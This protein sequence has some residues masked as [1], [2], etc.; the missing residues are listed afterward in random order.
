MHTQGGEVYDRDLT[1]RSFFGRIK[2]IDDHLDERNELVFWP[3]SKDPCIGKAAEGGFLYGELQ[4][5]DP[6][7][8][9]TFDFVAVDEAAHVTHGESVHSALTMAA[10]EGRLYLS[11]PWGDDNFHARLCDDR[12]KGWSYLRL[13]WSTHPVYSAG[14][15]VAGESLECELCEGNRQGLKWSAADPRAHRYPGKLTS[16]WYDQAVLDKT[17]EQVASELDIDRAGAL[18]ARVYGEFE[19]GVHEVPAGVPY[20]DDV[21][22]E[23]GWDFGLDC[24][25]VPVIQ[26]TPMCVNVI[27]LFEAGDKFKWGGMP[28][29]VALGLRE[30]LVSIGVPPEAVGTGTRCVG[31]PSGA[32]RD[33]TSA[34]LFAAYR[35]QGFFIQPPPKA[36][37]GRVD[38]S[39]TSV[40]NLLLGRPKPVRVCGVNGREFSRHMLNNVWPT[41][42]EGNRKIGVG[43]TQPLDNSH[44]HACRAFAYW[45]VSTFPPAGRRGA[46]GRSAADRRLPETAGIPGRG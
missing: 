42:R 8:G 3:F 33:Q 10:P 6:G 15:H 23:L 28:E 27:G 12:P 46:R 26:N 37:R 5:D 11:T 32:Y 40:K 36:W 39:V 35:E 7:R 1:P 9:G 25:A 41:D 22:V 34:G 14:L 13:H 44:N 2:Y 24:T 30:Y 31:D 4:R 21:P 16:P 17:D 19:R 38:Y 20:R 45:S 29:Q 43:N 18:T